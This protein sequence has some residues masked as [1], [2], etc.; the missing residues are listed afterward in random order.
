MPAM[1]CALPPAAHTHHILHV[2]PGVEQSQQE[3]RLL[4]QPVPILQEAADGNMLGSPGA[5]LQSFPKR[6]KAVTLRVDNMNHGNKEVFSCRGIKLAVDWFLERGHRD[7]TV[8]VPAWR[9]E[10]SRPDAL[11]TAEAEGGTPGGLSTVDKIKMA[12]PSGHARAA[13]PRGCLG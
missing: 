10:Q 3:A 6:W 8:F 7:I 5:F 11:I 1:F 4:Q 2:L 12:V 9:K 13:A